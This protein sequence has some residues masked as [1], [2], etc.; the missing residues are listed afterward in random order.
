MDKINKLWELMQDIDSLEDIY[1]TE[2]GYIAFVFDIEGNVDDRVAQIMKGLDKEGYMNSF[3]E[4]NDSNVI[5]FDIDFEGEFEEGLDYQPKFISDKSI[6]ELQD[7]LNQMYAD[8]YKYS[9]SIDRPRM[10]DI[11]YTIKQL[12]KG[13][14]EEVKFEPEYVPRDWKDVYNLF[15]ILGNEEDIKYLCNKHKGEKAWDIACEKWF[16]KDKLEEKLQGSVGTVKFETLLNKYLQDPE[17]KEEWEKLQDDEEED[18]VDSEEESSEDSVELDEGFENPEGK[19]IPSAPTEDNAGIANLINALIKD[20]WDAIDGYQ[21]A[22]MN[23]KSYSN[24]TDSVRV[25]EEIANDEYAHVGNLQKI[26][27]RFAPQAS[28]IADGAKEAEATIK[29]FS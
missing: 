21:S 23:I 5:I 16:D 18:N 15:E 17:F 10:W 7:E 13:L 12:K 27:N 29:E 3:E 8:Q 26:L 6:E 28:T 24:D 14:K 25:L 19:E 9:R 1:E 20:E 4:T 2:E 11:N 22:I